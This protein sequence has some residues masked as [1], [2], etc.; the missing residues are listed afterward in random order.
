[1]KDDL[2]C[3]CVGRN[4]G[5]SVVDSISLPSTRLKI[6]GVLVRGFTQHQ[7]RALQG[8]PVVSDF[9]HDP[10]PRTGLWPYSP[11]GA[12]RCMQW[13]ISDLLK[14][15]QDSRLRGRGR[16][17]P[18]YCLIP[19]WRFCVSGLPYLPT[20]S[21]KS[22]WPPFTNCFRPRKTAARKWSP[23]LD[24]LPKLLWGIGRDVDLSSQPRLRLAERRRQVSK[25]CSA[26]HL[27]STSLIA[28]SRAR[29][30]AVSN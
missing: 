7:F 6:V 21:S 17:G 18:A 15:Q 2:F 13:R 9:A 30:A 23:D 14:G 10:I 20:S 29:N 1:M 25:T 22:L 12:Q 28:C 27:T 8:Q 5:E 26:N 19:S 24:F 4:I 11:P 3:F 16:S